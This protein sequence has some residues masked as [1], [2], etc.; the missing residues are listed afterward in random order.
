MLKD[1]KDDMIK[2]LISKFNVKHELSV[3]TSLVADWGKF[4]N[5]VIPRD[6]D[7]VIILIPEDF[8]HNIKSQIKSVRKELSV[9]IM[10]LPEIRGNLH[11]LY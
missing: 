8:D 4:I 2:K 5:F 3:S 1:I 7:N 6:T 9:I 11:V 10:K